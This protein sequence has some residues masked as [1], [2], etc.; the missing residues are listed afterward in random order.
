MKVETV[1]R[2]TIVGRCPLGCADV[3]DAEFRVTGDAVLQVERIAEAVADLTRDPVF[4]EDLTRRL[5]A[6]LGCVVVTRGR[7]GVFDTECTAGAA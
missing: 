2:T 7:H 5:A 4:Q 1:H 6:R 3:Y